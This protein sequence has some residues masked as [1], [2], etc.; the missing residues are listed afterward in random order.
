MAQSG[1]NGRV[2]RCRLGIFQHARTGQRLRTLHIEQVLDRYR[3]PRQRMLLDAHLFQCVRA[4]G[5][6]TRLFAVHLRE[7]NGPLPR[8]IVDPRQHCFDGFK[9][10]ECFHDVPKEKEYQCGAPSSDVLIRSCLTRT[11]LTWTDE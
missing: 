10:G 4:G 7:H 1:N 3:H 8:R 5:G 9:L 6:C 11:R 2:V